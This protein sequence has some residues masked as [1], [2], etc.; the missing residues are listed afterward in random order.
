[1]GSVFRCF[2]SHLG[3]IVA[4]KVLHAGGQQLESSQIQRFQKEAK[5]AGRLTHQ[6]LVE[7]LDFG[8]S[9][10][11]EPYMVMEFVEGPNLKKIIREQG[12]L[13]LERALDLVLQICS[14]M[15]YSHRQGVIHRDLKSAN[16][17]VTS[18]GS[19]EELVKVVDF[20][21]ARSLEADLE[22]SLEEG[23]EKR[24]N[25]RLTR[26]NALLG[27]P[28]YMSPEASRGG[29][30]DER[31]DIYSLG[32]II[33]ECLAGEPPF[34][35]DTAMETLRMHS[36]EEPPSLSQAEGLAFPQSIEKLVSRMLAKDPDR[37]FQSMDEIVAAIQSN[38][39]V[40]TEDDP[41]IATPVVVKQKNRNLP[42][43]AFASLLALTVA[44]IG[45]MLYSFE[46]TRPPS[47]FPISYHAFDSGG[48]NDPPK[49]SEGNDINDITFEG[50][51]TLSWEALDMSVGPVTLILSERALK[52]AEADGIAERENISRLRILLSKVSDDWLAHLARS[53][54]LEELF[55]DQS[56]GFGA[57]GIAAL[58]SMKS[59]F[60]LD[61]RDAGL[62]DRDAVE[63]SRLTGL[64]ALRLKDEKMITDATAQA[65]C[66]KLKNLAL[67]DLSGTT[68]SDE[69]M[70]SFASLEKL[71][72][73]MLDSTAVTDRGLEMLEGTPAGA[74][75][76]R[77]TA[78]TPA[79]LKR[80]IERNSRINSI[81][82]SDSISDGDIESLRKLR[83]ITF[84]R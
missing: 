19:G 51:E 56:R 58:A 11:D 67:L 62:T 61:I 2:D 55:L 18:S 68:I 33:F 84:H 34:H 70:K 69:S 65:I 79:G 45:V 12:P 48:L 27:S 28:L 35:G 39:P 17:I 31:S 32:C 72:A 57:E 50:K 44:A 21:I 53:Q 7:I 63:T 8:M 9:G 3:K 1:M 52:I 30:A 6:N 26:T 47:T 37:R 82:V 73:L 15:S 41:E 23:P 25:V 20:G 38:E 14:A 71:Q 46:T 60:R 4:I 74:I 42:V 40:E 29:K 76:L 83:K 66:P 80:L 54:S 75:Y 10:S 64:A 13:S 78:V 77:N 43:L 22:E 81:W 16:I 36:E 5:L 59:L 24:Q 49:P